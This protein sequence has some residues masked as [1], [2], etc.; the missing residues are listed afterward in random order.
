MHDINMTGGGPA[1][2]LGQTCE[3]RATVKEQPEDLI[4]EEF[5]K[6]RTRKLSIYH[7]PLYNE[8]RREMFGSVKADGRQDDQDELFNQVD[9]EEAKGESDGDGTRKDGDLFQRNRSRDPVFADAMEDILQARD[10]ANK[11]SESEQDGSVGGSAGRDCASCDEDSVRTDEDAEDEEG[12]AGI[13]QARDKAYG[14]NVNSPTNPQDINDRVSSSD[15]Q[16]P[17]KS[18][19]G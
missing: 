2:A 16:S 6:L 19:S 8:K 15:E 4:K 13:L 12:I 10:K 9:Q 7:D 18:K 14:E 3:R 17:G 11:E 5:H 1:G